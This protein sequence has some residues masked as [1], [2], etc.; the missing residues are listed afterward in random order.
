[1]VS[2]EGEME[3]EAVMVWSGVPLASVQTDCPHHCVRGDP[4]LGTNTTLACIGLS[5]FPRTAFARFFPPPTKL[6]PLNLRVPELN[7]NYLESSLLLLKGKVVCVCK[8]PA[9]CC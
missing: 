4:T 8:T 7:P 3:E 1:M 9:G 2:Y 6:R 5:Y